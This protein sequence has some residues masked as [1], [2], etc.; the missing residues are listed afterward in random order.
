MSERK[1]PICTVCRVEKCRFPDRKGRVP[2]NCPMENYADVREESVKRGWTQ[3][4]ERKINMACEEVLV[5]AYGERGARLTRVEELIEYAKAMG[6]KK[7]GLGFCA[8]LF[9]EARIMADILDK[10]GFDVVS[11]SCMAG[12]AR[13]REDLGLELPEYMG[14]MECNPLMQAEVL[15]REG[16]EFNVMFGLCLGHDIL[17]IK[18]S[19][20]DVTP[21]VVKDRV[22]CHNPLGTIYNIQSYYKKKLFSPD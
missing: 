21:L 8:G 17:F 4:E 13:R 19:K 20:A 22:L 18:N 9:E 14:A 2:A 6:Y 3:P 10:E 7:I 12:S 15:N 16:T 5:K 1:T 11:I